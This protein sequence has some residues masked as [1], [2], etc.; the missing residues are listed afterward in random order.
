MLKAKQYDFVIDVLQMPS[1][2]IPD[3]L[4]KHACTKK[5]SS[6]WEEQEIHMDEYRMHYIYWQASN[7]ANYID[8]GPQLNCLHMAGDYIQ[9]LV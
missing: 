1:E 5:H 9:I 7:C 4:E 6:D 2:Q 3:W 8:C